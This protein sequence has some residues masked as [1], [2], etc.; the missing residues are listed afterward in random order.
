M[1]NGDWNFRTGIEPEHPNEL[2]RFRSL[3]YAQE[4]VLFTNTARRKGIPTTVTRS[5]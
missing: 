3:Q 4:F 2:T 5:S 1:V